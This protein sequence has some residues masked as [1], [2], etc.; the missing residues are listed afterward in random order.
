MCSPLSCRTSLIALLIYL[1]AILQLC[2]SEHP[3]SSLCHAASTPYHHYTGSSLQPV[4]SAPA[5]LSCLSSSSLFTL[6][7]SDPILE[8]LVFA[9]REGA[10]KLTF[11]C[12]SCLKNQSLCWKKC[13]F[14]AA[15]C[16]ATELCIC[17]SITKP[18]R[19]ECVSGFGL[20]PLWISAPQCNLACE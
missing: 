14:R 20:T 17:S 19:G 16:K 2:S 10:V 6:I 3:H 13:S 7:S 11:P 18:G 15:T 4:A 1:Q 9:A 8:R 5:V 12:L